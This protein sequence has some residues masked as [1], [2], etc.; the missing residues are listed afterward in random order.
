[1]TTLPVAEARQQFSSLVEEAVRT[2]QRIRVTRNGRPAVVVIADD[3][4]E[5]IMETIEV[6]SDPTLMQ[7]VVQS[8]A[9]REAGR[10]ITGD[11]MAAIMAARAEGID[12]GD[13]ADVIS[14]MHASG[15]P[16]EVCMTALEAII[17]RHREVAE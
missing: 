17:A 12:L 9:D 11:E 5:A 8:H 7:A 2:H 3:D 14:E 16:D 13:E 4:F 15:I 1:M 10:H 6:L